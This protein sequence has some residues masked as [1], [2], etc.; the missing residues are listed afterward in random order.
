MEDFI[1]EEEILDEIGRQVGEKLKAQINEEYLRPPKPEELEKILQQNEACGF[2][3]MIGSIDCMHWRWKNCPKAWA[4]FF[5][6]GDKGC[7]TMILEAVAS[8]DRC[9][10]HAIFGTFGSQN[11]INI[12][13]K[14]PL[15][16][17]QLKGEAP[18]VHYSVNGNPYNTPYYLADGIYP[19]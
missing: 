8:H 4:G 18:R 15:F 5:T 13:N 19:E 1:A 11:D 2:P 7:P 9:I 16:I 6:R 12:L 17:N 10:W 3:D 14:S